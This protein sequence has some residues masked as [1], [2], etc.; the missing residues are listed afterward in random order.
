MGKIDVNFN[1]RKFENCR[2]CIFYNNIIK[3]NGIRLID[4]S[5]IGK[6]TLFRMEIWI[7]KGYDLGEMDSLKS[8]LQEIFGSL[9]NESKI[10]I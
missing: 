4:K 7:R 1:W 5:Q 8:Y 3:V 2:I 6:K 9:V 10:I